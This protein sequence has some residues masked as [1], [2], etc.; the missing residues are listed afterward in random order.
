MAPIDARN[1][2]SIGFV[3]IPG[4]A[5]MSYASASEPLRAAN[6]LAGREIYRLSI[7]SPDGIPAVSS[8]GVPVPADPL[9]GRG[10]ELGTV[11]VCAGGSPRD[12]HYPSVL[13][14]LRQLAR[15]GVR[16]GGISGGPYLLAAAGLLAERDFTIHWEH[17]PALLEAF[18]ALAPRQARFVIDGNRITCGGGIAPLDMMH[19]LISEHMGADFARRVSDWY[20]HTEVGE[21][22]APQRGSLAERY[23][24]HHPGLLSVLAKMEE[25]I[26]M[27]LDRTAMARIAGVTPRHLDRL[28]AS[29]LGSTFLDQYRLIRLRHARRLLEQSPLSISEIAIATGFSSGAHFSRAYRSLYGMAP[30]ETRR[31]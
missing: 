18:P 15:E 21:P 13:A 22:A 30:S 25:T 2:Q 11:F 29:H 1:S 8:G 4:F 26:E 19:V 6:L 20:L 27:P 17:A 31:V 10:S 12:W 16:I 9:P 3:L 14:C 7:F 24:V 28:F 5:L 23:G